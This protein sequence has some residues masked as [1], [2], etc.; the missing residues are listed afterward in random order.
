MLPVRR[1]RSK[2]LSGGGNPHTK[3]HRLWLLQLRPDQVHDSQSQGSPPPDKRSS[4]RH[5][6]PHARHPKSSVYKQ[7]CQ[8]NR[9]PSLRYLP[10]TENHRIGHPDDYRR[11]RHGHVHHC[12][13][14]S[15]CFGSRYWLPRE[16]RQF[17]ATLGHCSVCGVVHRRW[18]PRDYGCRVPPCMRF[19]IVITDAVV[20]T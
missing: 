2:R 5:F 9:F 7:E 11:P 16:V 12:F 17:L 6:A 19:V 4:G 15:C 8:F 3:L 1:V 13:Y 14:R 20:V 18:R 10:G